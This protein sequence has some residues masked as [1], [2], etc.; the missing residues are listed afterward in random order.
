MTAELMLSEGINDGESASPGR[1]RAPANPA[2]PVP[3]PSRTTCSA[4]NKWPH[5]IS[6]RL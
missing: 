2:G 4:E 6:D 5:C 3:A 1:H